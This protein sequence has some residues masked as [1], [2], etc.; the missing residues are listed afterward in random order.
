MSS[1]SSRSSLPSRTEFKT[2]SAANSTPC[3]SNTNKIYPVQ[4]PSGT[5][6]FDSTTTCPSAASTTRLFVTPE[7]ST[8]RLR[9]RPSG[10]RARQSVNVPPTSSQNCHVIGSRCLAT[11]ESRQA[12]DDQDDARQADHEQR[13]RDGRLH[14]VRVDVQIY[15]AR[16]NFHLQPSDMFFASAALFLALPRLRHHGHVLDDTIDEVI[17]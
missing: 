15:G 1:V 4:K 14:L 3:S 2:M 12:H 5:E 7:L 17:F 9:S 11:A 6:T 13:N 16:E 8:L 10:A